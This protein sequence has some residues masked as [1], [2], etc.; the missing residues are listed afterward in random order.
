M[1]TP[2]PSDCVQ[3]LLYDPEID[4]MLFIRDVT[5]GQDTSEWITYTCFQAVVSN[6]GHPIPALRKELIEK[7]G[8][9]LS[10]GQYYY[11]QTIIGPGR[12]D[13]TQYL[14]LCKRSESLPPP[15]MSANASWMNASSIMSSIAFDADTQSA[16]R[17]F[18]SRHS[19][20]ANRL[21]LKHMLAL[22][23]RSS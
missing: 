18:A 22:T 3:A 15:S 6:G 1:G 21:N 12:R 5:A 16:L 17:Q 20:E 23:A 19:G 2:A 13:C 8:L 9:T 10:E 11:L 7:L 14:V 4:S